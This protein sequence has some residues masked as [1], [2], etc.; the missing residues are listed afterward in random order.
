L[1]ERARE[2]ILRGGGDET[3]LLTDCVEAGTVEALRAVQ[4]LFEDMYGGF[5]FNY[6][7]KAAAAWCL[8]QWGETGLEALLEGAYR[9]PKSKNHCITPD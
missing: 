6:E 2:F 3:A 9:T 4:M 7:L 5:T 8:M 1:E